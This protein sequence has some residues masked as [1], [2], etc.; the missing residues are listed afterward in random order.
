MRAYLRARAR[1][2][3]HTRFFLFA[4]TQICCTISGQPGWRG[5]K[6]NRKVGLVGGWVDGGGGVCVGGGGRGEEDL[7]CNIGELGRRSSKFS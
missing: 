2:G 7:L 3:M 6:S 1:V 4:F 5:R